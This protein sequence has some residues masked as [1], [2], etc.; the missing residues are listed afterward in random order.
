MLTTG[1]VHPVP[2]QIRSRSTRLHAGIL[3][4][5]STIVRDVPDR[6]RQDP[7]FCR[8]GEGAMRRRG[9]EVGFGGRAVSL[10]IDV[11]TNVQSRHGR[12]GSGSRQEARRGIHRVVGEG[13]QERRQSV[14][15]AA[16]RDAEAVQPTA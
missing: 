5:I 15:S 11:T 12:R 14:R 16:I 1:R 7:R 8:S 13:Q 4:H 3:H 10:S 9:A 2:E 6:A